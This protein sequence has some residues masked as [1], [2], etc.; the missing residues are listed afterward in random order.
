[1]KKGSVRNEYFSKHDL[2][3]NVDKNYAHGRTPEPGQQWYKQ[4]LVES[5]LNAL[6]YS[7]EK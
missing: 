1:M 4:V 6:L 3:F 2:W 5:A 7:L